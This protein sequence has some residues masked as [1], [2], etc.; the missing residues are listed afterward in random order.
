MSNTPPTQNQPSWM[1]P[2]NQTDPADRRLEVALRHTHAL[3]LRLVVLAASAPDMW[4][5]HDTRDL[6]ETLHT[7]SSI[8]TV[9][10]TSVPPFHCPRCGRGTPEQRFCFRCSPSERS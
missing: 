5:A 6:Q 10:A 8:A 1:P 3:S 9:V 7:L 4:R 2:V